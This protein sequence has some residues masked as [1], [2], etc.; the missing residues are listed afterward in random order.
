MGYQSTEEDQ[1]AFVEDLQVL[2]FDDDLL[3]FNDVVAEEQ[4]DH[5]DV[6]IYALHATTRTATQIGLVRKNGG[7]HQQQQRHGGTARP[8]RGQ[9][10]GQQ[11]QQQQNQ[12]KYCTFCKRNN[13]SKEQCFRDPSSPAY[14]PRNDQGRQG[15]DQFAAMQEKINQMSAMK[16]RQCR[17]VTKTS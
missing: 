16:W 9:K 14:R 2:L 15:R 3:M 11:H 17:S 4:L 7:G 8:G 12:G 13:H 6:A 1:F 5:V 10:R